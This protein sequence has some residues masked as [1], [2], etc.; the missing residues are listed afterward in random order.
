MRWRPATEGKRGQEEEWRRRDERWK[1]EMVARAA[2]RAVGSENGQKTVEAVRWV[3]LTPRMG[4]K[5]VERGVEAANRV[6]EPQLPTRLSRVL[7]SMAI[8]RR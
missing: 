3:E 1:I 5:G 4:G 8:F 2:R 7:P 6:V